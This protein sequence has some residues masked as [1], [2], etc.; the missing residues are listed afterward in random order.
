MEYVIPALL[1]VFVVIMTFLM[2]R[3]FKYAFTAQSDFE[4][5]LSNIRNSLVAPIEKY[6][7]FTN[8][9]PYTWTEVEFETLVA[10]VRKYIPSRWSINPPYYPKMTCWFRVDNENRRIYLVPYLS[11][12]EEA[13]SLMHYQ[14]WLESEPDVRKNIAEYRRSHS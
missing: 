6:T 3:A 11:Q 9:H 8:G 2:I 7:T 10:Q 1:Y 4:V 12:F 13:E 14:E 5:I